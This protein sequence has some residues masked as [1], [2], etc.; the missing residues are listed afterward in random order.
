M[1]NS[2]M[3]YD[4]VVLGDHTAQD[5]WHLLKSKGVRSEMF[6]PQG[7]KALMANELGLTLPNH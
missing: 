1:G 4:A 5:N 7:R 3:F 2:N 6:D